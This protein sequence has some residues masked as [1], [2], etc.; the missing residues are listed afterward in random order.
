MKIFADDRPILRYL[1]IIFG[2]II[3]LFLGTISVTLL[4]GVLLK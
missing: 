2:V 1:I 4:L 3:G